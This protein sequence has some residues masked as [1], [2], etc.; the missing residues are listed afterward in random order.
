MQV[1]LKPESAA[2]SRLVATLFTQL[3]DLQDAERVPPASE[4]EPAPVVVEPAP[5]KKSRKKPATPSSDTSS[6]ISSPA[7]AAPPEEP[8][9]GKIPSDSSQTEPAQAEAL[10]EEPPAV[11][12]LDALRVAFGT[13]A[14]AGK[15]AQAVTVVRN[16]GANGLAEIPEDKRA[17]VLAE[18]K[19]L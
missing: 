9:P 12:S 15:R 2:E 4:P 8:G 11:V 19:A 7:E 13:L 17:A 5:E 10:A 1:S 18:F 3:A 14:Q 6:G 16:H